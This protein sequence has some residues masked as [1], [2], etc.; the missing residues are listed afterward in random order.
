[1]KNSRIVESE[2]FISRS[3]EWD[4]L[5]K[6]SEKG[7]NENWTESSVIN[8]SSIL[9]SNL[10]LIP[11]FSTASFPCCYILSMHCNNTDVH[12]SYLIIESN[13][14]IH[15]ITF[16]TATSC[17]CWSLSLSSWYFAST[18]FVRS[19]IWSKRSIKLTYLE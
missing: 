15:M 14:I 12:Y 8:G 4:K 19:S 5:D 3:T 7:E 1:M 2:T 16:W 6:V 11:P 9:L 18:I 17:C 10:A 13:C